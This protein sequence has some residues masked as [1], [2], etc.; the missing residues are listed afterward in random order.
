M[1]WGMAP[2]INVSTFRVSCC[3]RPQSAL[4]LIYQ[5]LVPTMLHNSEE[6]FSCMSLL[7][8]QILDFYIFKL[9]LESKN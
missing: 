9:N 5:T 7:K 2:S 6:N 3:F 4:E 1:F 8:H